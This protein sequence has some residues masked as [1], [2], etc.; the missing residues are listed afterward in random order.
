EHERA[1]VRWVAVEIQRAEDAAVRI[2]EVRDF[3]LAERDADAVHVTHH[4]HR[5]DMREQVTAA[6][7]AQRC[8]LRGGVPNGLPLRGRARLGL[9][10]REVLDV[11]VAEER[12]TRADATRVEAD[13]V[14]AI[15]YLGS[16]SSADASCERN[17]GTAGATWI[18][19]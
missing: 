18:H 6:L 16:Q 7:L 4:I 9:E 8:E 13:E 12:R 3:V 10:C 5:S 1:C 11:V 15:L 2:A 17:A 19:Q 14:E